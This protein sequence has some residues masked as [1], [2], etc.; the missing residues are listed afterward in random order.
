LPLPSPQLIILVAGGSHFL[1]ALR[2][3][4][5]TKIVGFAPSLPSQHYSFPLAMYNYWVFGSKE[6]RLSLL[7]G[8]ARN[9]Y[10]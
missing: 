10:F 6:K 3:R 5:F 8:Q 1:F 2:R 9:Y 4:C 7:D